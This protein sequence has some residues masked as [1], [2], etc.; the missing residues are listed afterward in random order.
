MGTL[1]LFT[2]DACGYKAEVSG[3]DDAGMMCLTTTIVCEE[4][5][6]LY[7]VATQGNPGSPPGQHRSI[8]IAC[9]KSGQHKVKRWRSARLCPKC[10]VK[11]RRGEVTVLWD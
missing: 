1:Y 4:C 6:R 8:K 10:N 5:R 2:C 11:M 7:D 3:G 9:P